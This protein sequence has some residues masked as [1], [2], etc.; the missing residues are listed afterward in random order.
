MKGDIVVVYTS[1]AKTP[2]YGNHITIALSS[3]DDEG[4]FETVEGNAKGEGPNGDWREG[5]IKR[6][7]SIFDVAHIYRLNDGDYD[8]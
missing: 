5:V 7:R 6:Q 3:P 8:E 4:N 2:D 1:S